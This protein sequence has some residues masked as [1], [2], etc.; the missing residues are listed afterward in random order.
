MQAFSPLLACERHVL[1]LPSAARTAWHERGRLATENQAL[2]GKVAELSR[3][4]RDL[5]DL[6]DEN[7]RLRSLLNFKEKS[8]YALM[9]A[10][11]IGRDTHQWNNSIL[12]DKGIRDGVRNEMV[13]VCETGVVGKVIETAPSISTVLLLLSAQSKLGGIVEKT[14][15]MGIVEGTLFHALRLIYLPRQAAAKKGDRVLT[16]GLGGVYPKGLLI[17]VCTGVYEGENGLYSCADVLPGAD[18][19]R[20][21]EVFVL[22]PRMEGGDITR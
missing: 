12:I 5:R 4:L 11:V 6:K 8:A 3:D 1:A 15:E 10:E 18:F 22:I 17:G 2:R 16:S 13:V 21:E 9:P 14:R 19:S 20:L 7:N